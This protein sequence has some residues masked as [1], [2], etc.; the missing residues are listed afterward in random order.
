[1]CDTS[2]IGSEFTPSTTLEA[3]VNAAVEE[4]EME[5]GSVTSITSSISDVLVLGVIEYRRFSSNV[6][7]IT[8]DSW[9]PERR[10]KCAAFDVLSVAACMVGHGE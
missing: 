9:V 2:R 10:M 8:S 3:R 6:F 5:I 4:S 1:M 7:P